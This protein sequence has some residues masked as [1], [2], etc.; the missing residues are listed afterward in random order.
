LELEHIIREKY[1]YNSL[2]LKAGELVE[3]LSLSEI[4]MT[5]DERGCLDKMPFMPEMAQYCGKKFIVYKRADKTCLDTIPR[6]MYNTVHLFN[7]RCDGSAHGDCDTTCILFWK[8]AWLKRVDVSDFNVAENNKLQPNKTN[9]IIDSLK[10]LS[11]KTKND[12]GDGEEYYT[13]Q[14]TEIL[15]S[16]YP[17]PWWNVMQ[18]WREYKSNNITI[19][20]ALRVLCIGLLNIVLN[21]RGIGRILFLINGSR[22]Y[23][24]MNTRLLIEGKTP[25]EVLN[26]MPGEIVEVKKVNEIL[27]T[28]NKW[29]NRGLSFDRAGEHIKYCG[30]KYK[31]LKRVRKVIDEKT[32]KLIVL[33]NQSIILEGVICCAEYSK[34]RIMCPRSNYIFWREI[35]L[36]RED[37]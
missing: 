32:G 4:Y 24:F 13:C 7:L 30:K 14:A 15:N 37:V 6:R 34:D 27:K 23:P 12:V 18:Y 8:E 20:K 36:K 16:T 31:V 28:L 26:L 35:W 1:K 2:D 10:K 17:L 29:R 21:L 3:V 11:I 22:R 19:F 5:L 25:Y 9:S 33:K